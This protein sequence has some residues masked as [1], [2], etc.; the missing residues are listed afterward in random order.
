M[1]PKISLKLKLKLF[2]YNRTGRHIIQYENMTVDIVSLL[3]PNL[4][5]EA[6]RIINLVGF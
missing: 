3:Y 5:D 6:V 4:E 2:P 1:C